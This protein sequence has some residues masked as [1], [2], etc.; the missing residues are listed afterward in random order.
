M[1]KLKRPCTPSALIADNCCER[2]K[3]AGDSGTVSRTSGAS[4]LSRQPRRRG[5]PGER[6]CLEQLH[7]M[8]TRYATRR[9]TS[10]TFLN[11]ACRKKWCAAAIFSSCK[12]CLRKRATA[13]Y[14]SC[15]SIPRRR[16]RSRRLSVPVF[17]KTASIWV[18]MVVIFTPRC[19]AIFSRVAPPARAQ[20]TCASAGL[21][22]NSCATINSAKAGLSLSRRMA[23]RTGPGTVSCSRTRCGN[24]VTSA[25]SDPAPLPSLRRVAP[26]APPVAASRISLERYRA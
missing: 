3:R 19:S 18:L 1:V 15:G 7:A 11:R 12:F 13:D 21:R 2:K 10:K 14:P 4:H 25:R 9:I 8:T 24:G 23:T 22:P 6:A 16:V 26:P 5:S 20:T 17:R